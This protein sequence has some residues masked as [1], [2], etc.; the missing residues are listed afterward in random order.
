VRTRSILAALV[1]CWLRPAPVAPAAERG[2]YA[3]RVQVHLALAGDGSV[4]VTET[5]AFRFVGGPFTSVVRRLST[6]DTDGIVDVAAEVDGVPFPVGRGAGTIR[7]ERDS[8]VVVT[9]RL[10]P[11]SDASRTLMLRYR[12]RGA[13]WREKGTDVLQWHTLHGRRSYAVG[14][15]S[16]LVTWPQG[17]SLAT[18]PRVSNGTVQVDESAR[19][20][21]IV[22]DRS[23]AP[24]AGL[25][26]TLGF[27]AGGVA[28][29]VAAWQ[30]RRDRGRAAMPTVAA[31][32]GAILLALVAWLVIFRIRH[33]H[34]PMPNPPVTD[35]TTPP[36]DLSVGLAAALV[37]PGGAASWPHALATLVDLAGRGVVRIEGQTG[38]SGHPSRECLITLVTRPTGLR[39]HEAGLLELL[40]VSKGDSVTSVTL[41]A[42]GRAAQSHLRLFKL[43]VSD[44]LVAG[45]LVSPEQAQARA[46]LVRWGL[47]LVVLAATGFIGA[48]FLA[49]SYNAWP[50]LVPGAVL[51]AAVTILVQ[52]SVFSVL[53]TAG[54]QRA[55]SWRS[56]FSFIRQVAKG[57]LS[58][59]DP[60]WFDR[61]LRFAVARNVGRDWVR[62]FEKAGGVD[63]PPAWFTPVAA[64]PG[65]HSPL[66]QFA[67]MLSRAQAAGAAK[68]GA[69]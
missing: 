59:A 62:A 20:A 18:A 49:P 2:L 40:F 61:Y 51:V 66:R 42:A 54:L 30:G 47:L 11:V 36:D 33:R 1:V 48:A 3:E 16:V 46:A 10:D 57:R 22:A 15:A 6:R 69:P 14:T 12:V 17:A 34:E 23:L 7:I 35:R 29:E 4:A 28:K 65:G 56:F 50:L 9:W 32:A 58:V 45:G 39:T 60:A 67:D 63:R 52:A 27:A 43:P 41:S 26:F 68:Q 44:E 24:G 25:D 53:S 13:T 8:G 19:R 64:A 21:T 31:S 37:H 55:A 5:T 38:R